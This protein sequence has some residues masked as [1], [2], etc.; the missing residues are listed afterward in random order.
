MEAEY[1]K[2][3]G[4]IY[5]AAKTGDNPYALILVQKAMDHLLVA[6]GA[7]T[8]MMVAESLALETMSTT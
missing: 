7:T 1:I 3:L 6:E 8:S 5:R 2:K 4:A